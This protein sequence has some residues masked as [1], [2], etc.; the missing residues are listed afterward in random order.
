MV[1][2]CGIFWSKFVLNFLPCGS[3]YFLVVIWAGLWSVF[4]AFSGQS[5]FELGV[6]LTADKM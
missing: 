3:L 5:F 6:S 2:Y 4:V 1:C